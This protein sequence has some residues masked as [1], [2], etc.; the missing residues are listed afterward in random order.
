MKEQTREE[1]G[2]LA[3]AERKMH[4]WAMSKELSDRAAKDPLDG[5]TATQRRIRFLTIS[6]EAGACG[7]EIGRQIGEHLG[8]DVYHRNLLDRI[9]E[10]FNLPRTMLDLVDETQAGWVYD[11][12]GT[13]MNHKLVPHEKY[14]ACLTR[15]IVAAAR[16]GHAVFV[17]RG[18]QFVL[19]RQEVFAVRIVA[20]QKHRVAQIMEKAGLTKD[21]A[22]RY[23]KE[24]DAGRH[25]FVERFFHH[26]INDP[27][28]Y[29]LVINVE[30]CGKATAIKEILGA[31]GK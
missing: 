25:K 15:V 26:D 18:A 23:V 14:V 3:A 2:I 16:K 11:V 4:A 7:A 24:I 22:S 6:R 20:S 8:W 30:R 12:L 13:W 10:R 21:Q 27:H 5:L 1:P 31:L 28:L 19:R 17:G 9:A 29:E